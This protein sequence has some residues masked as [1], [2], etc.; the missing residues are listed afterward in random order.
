[1]RP[2][3]VERVTDEN[4]LIQIRGERPGYLPLE[5]NRRPTVIIVEPKVQETVSTL[6][7]PKEETVVI[8]YPK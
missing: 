5:I 1:M 8:V 3:R 6:V 7:T 2:L 4:G